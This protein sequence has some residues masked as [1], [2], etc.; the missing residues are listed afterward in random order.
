MAQILFT[1]DSLSRYGA[2]RMALHYGSALIDAG[3]SV[4]VAYQSEPELNGPGGSSLP[5]FKNAG[6]QTQRIDRI[7][8]AVLPFACTAL[9]QLAESQ[10]LVIN[11]QIRDLAAAAAVA[12]RK[13]KPCLIWLQ[14][15]PGF[16]GPL[17]L[18]WLKKKVYQRSV[19]DRATHVVCVAEGVRDHVIE[20]FVIP[21][22]RISAIANG[23]EIGQFPAP[24][25]NER[26]SVHQEFGIANNELIALNL[27]RI[28]RQKGQDI[29]IRALAK[30]GDDRN[31][32][33][34]I[35]AGDAE[36]GNEELGRQYKRLAQELGVADRIIWA[37][38]RNDS[39]RLIYAADFSIL[40]SRWEG[41]PIT[42]LESFA[43]STPMLMTQYGTLFKDFIVGHHGWVS[44][45]EDV[46]AL[47]V[48]LRQ[49]CQLS[50]QQRKDVG[51]Q[52][53]QF[54]IDH[55]SLDKGKLRFVQLCESLID[56]YQSKAIAK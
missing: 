25:G 38:F 21:P 50:V 22:E 33:R 12:Q 17:P 19:R 23:L 26:E 42:L 46:D 6:I 47:A 35:I 1:A 30:M 20:H 28:S 11:V 7:Q 18:R 8:W 45:N 40:S 24:I 44:P 5:D 51:N 32:L 49:V 52:G 13:K 4:T 2:A 43:A 48:S 14:N 36:P 31:R 29:L 41:L 16:N 53:R 9:D 15:T 54:L 55:L 27:A 39:T 34:V 37:G 3:H 10:D 56:L